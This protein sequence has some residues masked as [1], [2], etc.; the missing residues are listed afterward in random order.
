MENFRSLAKKAVGVVSARQETIAS[1][2]LQPVFCLV[3]EKRRAGPSSLH[4]KQYRLAIPAAQHFTFY[5]KDCYMNLYVH[6]TVVKYE[7]VAS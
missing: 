2:P 3:R 7:G 4:T 1:T 5:F 6:D